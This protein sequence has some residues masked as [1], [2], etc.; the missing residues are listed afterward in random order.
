[1]PL[2]KLYFFAYGGLC[3]FILAVCATEAI[4]ETFWPPLG[5]VLWVR[6]A[7]GLAGVGVFGFGCRRMPEW[8]LRGASQWGLVCVALLAFGFLGL[9][10]HWTFGHWTFGR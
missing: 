10:V 3:C 7:G 2:G 4:V 5:D 8:F 9:F 6:V 1:M